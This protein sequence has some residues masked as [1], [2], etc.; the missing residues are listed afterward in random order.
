MLPAIP[1]VSIEFGFK[2]SLASA[3]VTPLAKLALELRLF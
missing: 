2:K 1:G 3:I